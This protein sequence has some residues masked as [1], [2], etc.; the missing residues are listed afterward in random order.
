MRARIV[1][2]VS[3]LK[4]VT[5]QLLEIIEAIDPNTPTPVKDHLIRLGEEQSTRL[6]SSALNLIG[7]KSE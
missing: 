3:A 5:D 4:G 6:V 7:I 2:V 1:A